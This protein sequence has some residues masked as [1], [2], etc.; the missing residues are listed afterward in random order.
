MK[1]TSSLQG[2][3]LQIIIEWVSTV[4]LGVLCIF[5]DFVQQLLTSLR[6]RA[7]PKLA[8]FN[9]TLLF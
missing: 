1:R 2:G 7:L 6:R 8:G 9:M 3:S 5:I 4:H